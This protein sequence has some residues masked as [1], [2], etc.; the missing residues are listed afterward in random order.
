MHRDPVV[1]EPILVAAY[2]GADSDL[3]TILE[4]FDIISRAIV[5]A[6]QSYAL[7]K[8]PL[9]FTKAVGLRIVQLVF[10]AV[11]KAVHQPTQLAPHVTALPR[12]HDFLQSD[13][14]GPLA[15]DGV[16]GY[17]KTAIEVAEGGEVRE[18][19]E[20]DERASRRLRSHDF[21]ELV[22]RGWSRG[23]IR[24]VAFPFRG[25]CADPFLA[26]VPRLR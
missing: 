25:R 23:R 21:F 14:S 6:H 11:T 2:R 24:L 10:F 9:S 16:S 20:G 15:G 13:D 4:D 17:L 5:K 18:Q 3:R 12:P 22:E 1:G 19:V 7:V 8:F 26:R